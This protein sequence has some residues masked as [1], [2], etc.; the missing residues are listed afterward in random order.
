MFYLIYSNGQGRIF[1]FT[2]FA[3]NPVSSKLY[4]RIYYDFLRNL[5]INLSDLTNISQVAIYSQLQYALLLTLKE[6]PSQVTCISNT[7]TTY[8][9]EQHQ[10]GTTGAALCTPSFYQLYRH[11][12][13][14]VLLTCSGV[15][16]RNSKSVACKQSWVALSFHSHCPQPHRGQEIHFDQSLFFFP[17]LCK[18]D[19]LS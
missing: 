1:A 16:E 6:H 17:F 4:I 7:R 2:M 18:Y 9:T 12:E 14:A 19:L 13:F 11:K 8:L 3:C 5:F 15:Q 10:L